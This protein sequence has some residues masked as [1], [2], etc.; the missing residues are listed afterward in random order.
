MLLVL[1]LSL[2]AFFH[3]KAGQK[4]RINAIAIE[5]FFIIFFNDFVTLG[6]FFN[7]PE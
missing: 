1:R 5:L 6:S 4:L 7:T 2:L 3:E